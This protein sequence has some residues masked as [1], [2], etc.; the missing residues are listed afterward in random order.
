MHEAIFISVHSCYVYP[1]KYE[2]L[3][4][5][6]VT[7]RGHQVQMDLIWPERFL[8]EYTDTFCFWWWLHCF[9]ADGQFLAPSSKTVVVAFMCNGTRLLFGYEDSQILYLRI[10]RVFSFK[11]DSWNHRLQGF[12]FQPFC[13]PVEIMLLSIVNLFY[14]CQNIDF[15]VEF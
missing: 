14:S 10:Y 15:F 6:T 7:L 9:W 5:L 12:V 11:V 3:H 8:D 4:P 2:I 1:R 13:W